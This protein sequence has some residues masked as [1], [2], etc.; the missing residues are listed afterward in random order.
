MKVLVYP[1][2]MELGGSQFNAVQ[3]AEAVRDLGHQV[4]VASE[5]GPLMDRVRETGLEHIEIPR[6]RARP[7]PRVSQML[8]NIVNGGGVD[9]VHGHEWPPIVEAFLNVGLSTR[10][11]V[12]G[13]VMSMSVP[14]FL[15]RSVPLTV[16][17]EM[18]R[19]AA[20]AAGH[21][22]VTLLEP[23]V[24]TKSDHPLL[25][26]TSFRVAQ[27]IGPDEIVIAMVCRLVPNLKLEGLLS[28]CDAVGAM[29]L[30]GRTVRLLIIGDGPARPTVEA[31]AA[32]INALLGRT[33]VILVGEMSDPRPGYAAADVIIGQ[34]GSALRGMAFGKP[35]VVIGE[36]GFSELLTPESAPTFLQQG[37]YGLGRGSRGAGPDALRSALEVVL[38]S[39]S[40]R[41]ELG[42]FGRRLV[43]NRFSLAHA[44]RTIEQTYLRA[45]RGKI[46]R[47]RR[48]ADAGRCAAS[49]ARYKIQ[50]KYQRWMGLASAEDDNDRARISQVLS[51][52]A[53]TPC[54]LRAAPDP[55]SE[56]SRQT[57]P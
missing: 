29:G 32:R 6:H 49:L 3:L 48:L 5:T 52:R 26:G 47:G 35:L 20:V 54:S 25:D 15:P 36:D 51:A 41:Q 4:T 38:V 31:R 30:D 42:S 2:S 10:T 14:S 39:T 53:I 13:T 44:A 17:T 16:G 33:A 18:I 34:G 24:D 55:A 45:L 28:A 23:P 22:D 46:A 8:R 7:S 21:Q 12:V 1:H 9:V 56:V 57:D 50:R 43:E 27:N 37:W 40:L 19:R 11:A